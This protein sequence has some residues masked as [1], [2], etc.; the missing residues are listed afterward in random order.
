MRRG[1]GG[2]AIY[3]MS[4]TSP[5]AKLDRGSSMVQARSA[6]LSGDPALRSAGGDGS[7]SSQL[8]TMPWSKLIAGI[9]Q[10]DQH[11]LHNNPSTTVT[12]SHNFQLEETALLIACGKPES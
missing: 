12:N 4:Q 9:T 3:F 2:Q 11:K 5:I 1:P 10:P 7:E 8:V 6:T